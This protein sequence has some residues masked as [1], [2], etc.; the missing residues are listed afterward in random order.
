MNRALHRPSWADAC[1]YFGRLDSLMDTE[2]YHFEVSYKL[3]E[4]CLLVLLNYH[5]Q[6]GNHDED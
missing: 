5:M 2:T 6:G 3:V 1:Y 4:E